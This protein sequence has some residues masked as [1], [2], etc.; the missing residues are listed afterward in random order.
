MSN[1]FFKL[2][3]LATVLI[4]L[5]GGIFTYYSAKNN[6]FQAS[7]L[8]ITNQQ[9]LKDKGLFV[10][11]KNDPKLESPD[12]YLIQKNSL[13]ANCPTMT[14]TTQ[15]LGSLGASTE[16]ETRTTIIEYV[17]ESG[18]TLS[19]I[20]EKFNISLETVLWANDLTETSKIQPGKK[21]IILPV[22]G[23]L[24]LVRQN[25][26]LSQIA[27]KYKGKVEEIISF[28][29][30][31]ENGDIFIG[32]LL[33]IPN[34]K[35]PAQKIVYTETPLVDSYFIMPTQGIITQGLHW[36]NAIDVANKC[37]TPILAAAGGQVQKVGYN[38][39]PSGNYVQILHPNGV[40]TFYGH[41]SKILVKANE[42]I[43]QGQV[44]GY[45]GETGLATGCH[46]HF[47]VRGAKNPLAKYPLKSIISWK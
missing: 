43:S 11:S 13:M 30:L 3:G 9:F 21:L 34:G 15:V 29:E 45:M 36:Y 31:S 47:D 39:W 38:T 16:E 42:I 12:L 10:D 32:D 37:G 18:D 33:I 5:F 2:I 44:I 7:I 23:V 26:T 35:M 4:I 24:H 27:E 20:A 6:N 22:T 19:S 14:V 8:N 41:L 17:V 46:L 25:D 1:S 28:N 40:V